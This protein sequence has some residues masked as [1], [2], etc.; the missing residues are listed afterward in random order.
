MVL[1]PTEEAG[2]RKVLCLLDKS[3]LPSLISTITNGIVK[4]E[5]H[6]ECIELIV[7]YCKD[8]YDVLKRQKVTKADLFKYLKDENVDIS[9][10][11]DK[12]DMVQCC[13][14]FWQGLS[15]PENQLAEFKDWEMADVD[16][17]DSLVSEATPLSPDR[18]K[19]MARTFVGWFYER[20][21]NCDDVHQ[22]N[23]A[24]F[25][26]DSTLEIE[27]NDPGD[28]HNMEK[29]TVFGHEKVCEYIRNESGRAKVVFVPNV[30]NDPK[31]TLT[32]SGLAIIEIEGVLH[33][34][35]LPLGIFQHSFGL[36]QDPSSDDSQIWKIK[37]I[38]MT[39]KVG[40]RSL[41]SSS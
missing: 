7:K 15:P 35:N 9:P 26:P 18:L 25:W 11:A 34:N 28:Q 23:A 1:T 37:W 32:S 21:K 3:K 5:D 39:H 14:K 29:M 22:F 4:S 12:N 17:D 19:D 20:L 8:P 41:S 33:Q 36:I 31:A 6:S 2:L 24:L 10:K 40:S 16:N 38:K 27:I 13:L 30:Y